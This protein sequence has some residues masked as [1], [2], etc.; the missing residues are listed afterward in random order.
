MGSE[1]PGAVGLRPEDSAA[2]AFVGG[3]AEAMASRISRRSLLGRFGAAAI[4][5]AAGVPA[6]VLFE[7][8]VAN[9]HVGNSKYCYNVFA[10]SYC[11]TTYGCYCG[12]WNVGSCS[13]CD[14]CD[15]GSWC[16]SHGGCQG[17]G[18]PD[19]DQHTCCNTKTYSQPAGC[20]VLHETLII[21]RDAFC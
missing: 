9:A 5:S 3:L 12:C 17:H 19:P 11:N 21:C 1:L 20:G 15:K 13:F 8:G 7:P 10:T 14:C 4:A 18:N 16:G 2:F 6:A